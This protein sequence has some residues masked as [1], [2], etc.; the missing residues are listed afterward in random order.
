MHERLLICTDL[1]RTLIPN[2][3]Q[4][5]SPGARE[6]FARLVDCPEVVLVYV[7]GR[8]RN[9]VEAAI[10]EYALP[11]PDFAIG[12]VGTTIY[13]V[14]AAHAWQRD[15]AWEQEILRDWAGRSHRELAQALADLPNLRL[16]EA[17][18]Q[19]TC[20]LSYYVP[21]EIDKAAL[22][23]GIEARLNALGVRP[24][25]IWSLDEIAG[26]G[27]LDILPACASKLYAI[28][29]LMRELG[30]DSAQTVFCGDSGNDFEVLA[31]TVPA[32]LVANATTEVLTEAARLAREKGHE[33]RLYLARGNFRGMNG[34]YASG[35]LEG[36]EHYHPGSSA[37]MG[38][39]DDEG[40][41]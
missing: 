6:H 28:E 39:A 41:A 9:L 10:R 36:I 5:E 14:G 4:P 37:W 16:Q 29:A 1:D 3:T 15:A 26:T 24:R 21:A 17:T 20:K 7:S 32:V 23:R 19:N 30:F 13:R 35:I 31:S 22:S 33:D 38:F 2:G 11:V 27:L 8:D 34:N 12:D 25:L 18:K 40:N